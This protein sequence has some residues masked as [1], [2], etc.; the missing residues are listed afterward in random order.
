M[1]L[2]PLDLSNRV[3]IST[4][5]TRKL[6]DFLLAGHL[7]PG[8]RIPSERQLAASLGVGRS[9]VREALKSLTLLGL[10]E[11]R[12][13]DGT[14]MKKA[15][16]DLLPRV[17]EW[18]MLLGEKRIDDLIEA[19]EHLE[20]IVAGLAAERRDEAALTDL[21]QHLQDMKSAI[22]NADR[23]VA[24]DVAFHLKVAE[25][26]GNGIL[27]NVMSGIR[28]L[29]QVWI[30]RVMQ[31]ATDFRPSY[32]EHVPI[33]AAIEAGDADAARDAMMRHMESAEGRL[34]AATS[35]ASLTE[36]PPSQRTA[37]VG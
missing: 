4:E 3:T 13:G 21:R 20:V 5:I 22:G 9:V 29:L 10:V 8:D 16:S 26:S 37:S 24:A 30:K 36:S 28:T 11:V 27:Y 35:E 31:A 17:I 33:M 19:R 18:G 15:D 14:Y 6:L 12:Q 2:E 1:S 34:R 23:F 7:H 25:A 32:E